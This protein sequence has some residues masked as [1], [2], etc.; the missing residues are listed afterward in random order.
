[1]TEIINWTKSLLIGDLF[2]GNFAP[3]GPAESAEDPDELGN[4]TASYTQPFPQ[5]HQYPPF[6]NNR[7]QQQQQQH[8][9]S[10]SSNSP[11]RDVPTFNYQQTHSDQIPRIRH[12]SIP[13]APQ[14]PKLP[15]RQPDIFDM[16]AQEK[17]LVGASLHSET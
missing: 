17:Q 8:R 16:I 5:Q 3:P 11:S 14:T 4:S 2:V 12:D 13:P 9:I 7:S 10:E 15:T 6:S 1:M